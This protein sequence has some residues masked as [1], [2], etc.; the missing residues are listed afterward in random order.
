[1]AIDIN[2]L[3]STLE[4]KIVDL[5][6]SSFTDLLSAAITDGKNLLITLKD[7][8]TRRTQLL[9]EGKIT[10]EEFS[11]L[12]LADKDLT[13]MDALTQAGLALAKIDVFKQGIF[14]LIIETVISLV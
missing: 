11:V 12:V 2:T 1:M 7:D 6:K 5:A 10:K 14:K 3:L 13:E 8:L 9:A 4:G